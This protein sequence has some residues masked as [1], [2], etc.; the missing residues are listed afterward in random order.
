MGGFRL[1]RGARMRRRLEKGEIREGGVGANRVGRIR[2]G[3]GGGE[4]GGAWANMEECSEE[5]HVGDPLLR[6][7]IFYVSNSD[8]CCSAPLR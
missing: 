6:T 1:R 7:R 2:L 4:C 5:T 8:A 3:R